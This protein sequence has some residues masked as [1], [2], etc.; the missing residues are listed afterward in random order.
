MKLF[1]Y[2]I[3]F[4]L[5]YVASSPCIAKNYEKPDYRIRGVPE[6]IRDN[7][8]NRLQASGANTPQQIL[9]EMILAI[10]PYGY[11]HASITAT[12][13]KVDHKNIRYYTIQLGKPLVIAKTKIEIIGPGENNKILQQALAKKISIKTGEIF[14][15]EAYNKTQAM[16]FTVAR[17][18]GYVKAEMIRHEVYVNLKKNEAQVL[19]TLNTGPMF[20]YGYIHFSDSPYN[21]NFLNR[22]VNFKQGQAYSPIAIQNLQANLLSSKFFSSALVTPDIENADEAK[23]IP[24]TIETQPVKSQQYNF[25]LGYGTNTGARTSIGIDLYRI[26]NTEQHFSTLANLSVVNTNI[27]TTYFIPGKYPLTDQYLIGA[28]LGDFKPDAGN[29]YTKKI[30]T[31]YETK[32]EK[33]WSVSSN[34]NYLHERFTVN[35]NLYHTTDLVYPSINISRLSADNPINPTKGTRISLDV[36]AGTPGIDEEF[37]QSELS[38]KSIYPL[39][40]NN[41]L[42]LRG[43]VGTIYAKDYNNNFPLSMRYFAGGYNSVRGY[44]YDSLGPGRYLKVGSG[45]IQQRVY[46]Q[47]YI[48]FFMDEGNASD[49]VTQ[50]PER[51]LGLDFVYRTSVGPLSIVIAQ[52]STEPGK[53]LSIEFNFGTDI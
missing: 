41:F 18:H 53:P 3:L 19:L 8:I 33:I 12:E 44:S 40:K 9:K 30:F 10:Q 52:A 21:I 14:T 27:T 49:D 17:N 11:F 50:V 1:F 48:G 13:T 45:E 25:G 7:I 38:V 29:A 47:F 28:Y 46:D 16:M 24:I 43:D 5:G 37:L 39:T 4:F 15:T 6:N 34:L 23:E 32:L 2:I 51:S 22:F 26:A 42:I 20:Y 35:S 36:S 31:G